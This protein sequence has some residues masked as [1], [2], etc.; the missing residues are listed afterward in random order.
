MVGPYLV[1]DPAALI[2]RSFWR[3]KKHR[4]GGNLQYCDCAGGYYS[5]MDDVIFEEF[6]GTGNMEL[7][8]TEAYQKNAYSQQLIYQDQAQGEKTYCLHGQS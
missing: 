8:L 6:K 4:E 7:V 3:G 5:R 2:Q 1:T